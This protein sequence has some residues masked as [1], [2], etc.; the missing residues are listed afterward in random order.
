MDDLWT[1]KVL[2]ELKLSEKTGEQQAYSRLTRQ[3]QSE[4]LIEIAAIVTDRKLKRD[5]RPI[6]SRQQ[7]VVAK[8]QADDIQGAFSSKRKMEMHSSS[9]KLSKQQR[10]RLSAEPSSSAD[11]LLSEENDS[12]SEG[13]E[14]GRSPS[15]RCLARAVGK[16]ELALDGVADLTRESDFSTFLDMDILAVARRVP[17]SPDIYERWPTLQP[18]LDRVFLSN[19]YDEVAE[20]VRSENM[21]DPVAAYLFTIVMAYFHYFNFRSEVPEDI[22]EREGFAGL[23][24][25]FLQTPLTM[26]NLE[27]RYL[28]VLINAVSKRKNQGKDLLLTSKESGQFADA[29]ATHN[30][31]QLLLVEAAQLHNSEMKKRRQDE[32]KLARA[33]RDCWV[34]QV[35]TISNLS[36]PRRGLAV[37]GCASFKDETKL[38][39]LDYHGVFRLQQFDLFIIPLWKENFGIKMKSAVISCLQLAARVHDE[40]ALRSK[41]QGALDYD[42]CTLLS[43]A[44]QMIEKTTSSPV[45][46]KKGR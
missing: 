43:D 32:F 38:L 42:E 24:W 45:G 5:L 12:E 16:A 44:V 13:N 9:K 22:N 46:I 25:T 17:P 15:E 26:Y 18:I 3:T 28:E 2:R 21:R 37:Y 35:R 23:T 30:S 29:V 7:V 4:R 27:S 41:A 1:S 34:S 6:V 33:M 8:E 39:R 10:L 11:A 20:A 31:Q 14:G 19:G 40:I 36:V